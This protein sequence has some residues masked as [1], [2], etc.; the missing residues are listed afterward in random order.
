MCVLFQL[1]MCPACMQSLL[2]LCR[3]LAKWPVNTD[4]NNAPKTRITSVLDHFLIRKWNMQKILLEY[5]CAC[6]QVIG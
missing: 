1:E 5:Y 3:L 6:R 2:D 4:L